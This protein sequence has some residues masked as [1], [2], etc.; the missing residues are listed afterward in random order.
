MSITDD[1]DKTKSEGVYKMVKKEKELLDTF[2][3]SMN[4]GLL[5]NKGNIDV[6]GR[7]TISEPAT[8]RP[9]NIRLLAVWIYVGVTSD[10]YNNNSF[11]LLESLDRQ[12]AAKLRFLTFKHESKKVQRLFRKEVHYLVEVEDNL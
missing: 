9:I 7:A 8:G 4:T 6:N 12:S 11:E 10:S 5:M 3:Y 1:K 2:M